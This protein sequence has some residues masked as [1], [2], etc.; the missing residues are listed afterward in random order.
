M[1]APLLFGIRIP[2]GRTG[3]PQLSP[4]VHRD[5]A[6]AQARRLTAL[7]DIL[8]LDYVFSG[9]DAGLSSET[10]L[11]LLGAARRLTVVAPISVAAW[12]PALLARFGAVAAR[13]SGG[14]FAIDLRSGP[15]PDDHR[16]EEFARIVRGL[17]T[18]GR[19]D[20]DGEHFRARGLRPSVRPDVA[21]EIV[22][23]GGW[24]A[25][26]SLA[27]RTGDWYLHPGAGPD[28]VPAQVAA[29]DGEAA[30]TGRE[31]GFAVSVAATLE[32]PDAVA[33]RL[34]KYGRSGAG[35]VVL[36]LADP[37]VDLPVFAREVV[38]RVREL[39]RARTL[40]AVR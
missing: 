20:V 3:R 29:L 24:R 2:V 31:V 37:E 26:A 23:S 9:G 5:A 30:G 40:V 38:P 36:D 21:P 25:A 32:E 8:G 10:T 27:A 28:E 13:L 39:E 12:H 34:V 35:L 33:A 4:S 16:A 22:V 6:V 7:A 11:A 17:W 15:H 1:T 14:R 19:V 18:G